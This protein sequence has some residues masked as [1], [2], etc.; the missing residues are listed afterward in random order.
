MLISSDRASYTVLQMNLLQ[1]SVNISLYYT[2]KCSQVFVNIL[3]LQS[4]KV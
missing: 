4:A 1:G 2:M 3:M